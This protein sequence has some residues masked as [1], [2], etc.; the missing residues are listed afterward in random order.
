MTISYCS[1]LLLLLSII[2]LVFIPATQA[3]LAWP[4]LQG[5][6]NEYWRWSRP[7]IGKKQRVLCI[8]LGP[9]ASCGT[10]I[11][12]QFKALA[13]NCA[14]HAS[15]NLIKFNPR[16]SKRHTHEVAALAIDLVSMRNLIICSSFFAQSEKIS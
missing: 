5:S 2:V 9:V 3:H 8:A 16:C 12:R 10:L 13:V 1:I 15:L 7:S 11:C 4:S 14:D 6:R